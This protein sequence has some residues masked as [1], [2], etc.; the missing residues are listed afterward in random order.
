MKVSSNLSC[1][2][3]S[4]IQAFYHTVGVSFF[5]TSSLGIFRCPIF[6]KWGKILGAVRPQSANG[7][8]DAAGTNIVVIQRPAGHASLTTTQRYQHLVD[9]MMEKALEGNPL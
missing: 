2:R 9:R 3:R 8:T 7:Q 5:L 6:D 1:R 4:G